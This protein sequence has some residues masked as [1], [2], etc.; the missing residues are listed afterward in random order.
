MRMYSVTEQFVKWL[1]YNGYA[2]ST[3]PPRVGDEFVTVERTG[4]NVV[5]MVD[6]PEIAIQTWALT[7]ARAEEMAIAIRD[8]LLLGGKP[9]GVH[10]VAVDS[11]PYPFW[12]ESTG[13]PRYQIALVCASYLIESNN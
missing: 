3:Y 8:A 2:A 11:G 4:G 10:G 13:R 1:S 9:H 5:D 6:H 7:E 12:D